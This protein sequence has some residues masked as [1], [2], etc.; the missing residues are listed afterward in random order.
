LVISAEAKDLLESA[1]VSDMEYLHVGALDHRGRAVKRD[2]F[3]ANVLRRI[4][5]I[6]KDKTS[7]K[8]HP[9]SKDSMRRV[10]NLTVDDPKIGSDVT[11]FRM[12]HRPDPLWIRRD[13]VGKLHSTNLQGFKTTEL[14]D[15][16]R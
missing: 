11:V 12:Q 8:W 2:Y 7:F 15:L 10:S 5:C 14:E 6:D 3:V 1:N 16:K 9:I 13:L 4:D